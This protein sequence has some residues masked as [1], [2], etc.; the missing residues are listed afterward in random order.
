MGE[1]DEGKK[2]EKKVKKMKME[3]VSNIRESLN[4]KVYDEDIEKM[5]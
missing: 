2:I 3:G 5:K 4:V 1:E